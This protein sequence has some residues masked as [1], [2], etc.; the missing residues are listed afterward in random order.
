[1]LYSSNKTYIPPRGDKY[2]RLDYIPGPRSATM[3]LDEVTPKDAGRY[4]ARVADITDPVP[5]GFY[6]DNTSEMQV[7]SGNCQ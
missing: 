6:I 3:T 7:I 4:E 2:T 1:M 5:G